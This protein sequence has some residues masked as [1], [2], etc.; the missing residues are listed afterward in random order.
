MVDRSS[1]ELLT[2]APATRELS[3]LG[4]DLSEASLKRLADCGEI[5]AQRTSGRGVRLFRLADLAA[6]AKS[7]RS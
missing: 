1:N 6:F 4:V 2:A 3:R 7:R 5:P